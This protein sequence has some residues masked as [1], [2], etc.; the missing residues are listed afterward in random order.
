[1]CLLPMV[2]FLALLRFEVYRFLKYIG[3]EDNSLFAFLNPGCTRS[4]LN[5]I[6][7]DAFYDAQIFVELDLRQLN[8]G[9]AE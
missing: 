3:S 6:E 5:I 8:L 9:Q 7:V 4:H 2:D 1:M